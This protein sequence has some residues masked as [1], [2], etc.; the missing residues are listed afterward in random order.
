MRLALPHLPPLHAA[1]TRTMHVTRAAAAAAAAAGSDESA[2]RA[3]LL[4]K[5]ADISALAASAKR[6]AVLGIKTA[7]KADAP[8]YHVPEYLQSQGVQV[9]P[10]PV[11]YPEVTDILGQPVFRRVADVPQPPPLDVV[12]VFRRPEDVPAHVEDILAVRAR[13]L[14]LQACLRG[15]RGR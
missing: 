10:V 12:C 13:A 5:Q 15:R 6:V 4:T 7:A 8:A 9:V 3:N 11:Y 14:V 1:C 2:W